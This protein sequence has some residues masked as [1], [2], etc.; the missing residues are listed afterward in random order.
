M[1]SLKE[2]EKAKQ[3]VSATT[4]ATPVTVAE[5]VVEQAAPEP[6]NSEEVVNAEAAP[7]EATRELSEDIKKK[8]S[9]TTAFMD[10]LKEKSAQAEAELGLEQEEAQEEEVEF[11]AESE[12]EEEA[13][14][15]LIFKVDD[16][17]FESPDAVSE[18]VSKIKAENSELLAEVDEIRGFVEKISDPDMLEILKYVNMGYSTRVALVK[19]GFD[20]SIF[21]IE[22][23][24]VDAK[25]LVR[26]QLE[27]EQAIKDQEKEQKKLQKNMELSNTNLTEFA[28]AK[29]FDEA[30]KTTLVNQ[31][32]KIHQELLS[33]LVTKETLEIFSKGLNYESAV[34]QAA[35]VASI[36]AKNEKIVTERA[37][38]QAA[39]IPQLGRGIPSERK[40][41][42]DLVR[43][44]TGSFMDKVKAR[45]AMK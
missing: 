22:A 32:A 1:D 37:K 39:T 18:Y 29:G 31:M 17:E 43:V 14:A 44:P 38:K 41:L 35:E 9:G 34:K 5:T 30:K 2:K 27:R 8:M 4:E 20:E 13:P 40:Q 7:E 26:A 11:D 36:Q 28:T 3:A 16:Q 12:Q 42:K 25:E 21:Q 33:G 6:E 15:P 45:Q 24:D 19:A 23:D 10:R